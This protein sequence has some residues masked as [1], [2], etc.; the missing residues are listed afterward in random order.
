MSGNWTF[1][2]LKHLAQENRKGVNYRIYSILIEGDSRLFRELCLFYTKNPDHAMKT[3]SY[4]L[5]FDGE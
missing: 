2:G 1:L 3:I 5:R 4:L